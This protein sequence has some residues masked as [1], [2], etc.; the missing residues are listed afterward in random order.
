MSEEEFGGGASRSTDPAAGSSAATDV[1]LREYVS[2]QI[3]ALD[4]HLTSQIAGLKELVRSQ[5]EADQLAIKTADDASRQL[6][7]KHNDLIRQQEKKDATYATKNDVDRLTA[8]QSK[9]AGGLVV[10][11]VIGVA[12]LIKVWG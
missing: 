7:E 8:W 11:S 9:I 12:N 5:R 1:S 3:G 6:A 10:V 2:V 4:R